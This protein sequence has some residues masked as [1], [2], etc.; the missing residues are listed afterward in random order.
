MRETGVV[1]WVG[2][3]DAAV[4]AAEMSREAEEE[5]SGSGNGEEGGVVGQTWREVVGQMGWEV[6]GGEGFC[7]G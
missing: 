1:V 7:A 5:C 6:G 3:E 2:S 4:H